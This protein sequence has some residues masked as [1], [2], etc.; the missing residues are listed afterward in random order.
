M[1]W[2]WMEFLKALQKW[3]WDQMRAARGRENVRWL[4]R[5]L[6]RQDLWKN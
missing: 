2:W 1:N 4:K 3:T 5:E 6:R